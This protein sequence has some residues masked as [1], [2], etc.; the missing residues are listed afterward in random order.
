M[1]I[2][3]NHRSRDAYTLVELV[4]VVLLLGIFASVAAP[5]YG[6]ALASYKVNCAARR[7]AADL[8]MARDYA[9]RLSQAEAVDFNAANESYA[10][11]TMRNPDR[12][13]LAYTVSLT[14]SQY[15]VDIV[16]ALF[17]AVDAVQFD[18]YGRPN[19]SG[20]VVVQSKTYQRTIE[21]DRAGNVSIL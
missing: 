14:A 9:E 19:N 10:M 15:P 5:K 7:I 6:E 21:V 20:T 2:R 1:A 4:V 16:S 3:L 11:S 13:A 12:P 8:R 17:G 18:M